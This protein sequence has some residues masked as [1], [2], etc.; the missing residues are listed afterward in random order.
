MYKEDFLVQRLA[1]CAFVLSLGVVYSVSA[2]ELAIFLKAGDLQGES[3]DGVHKDEIDLV[4]FTQAF[5]ERECS[6][7]TVS[8]RIDRASP[9]LSSRAVTGASFPQMVITVV[10]RGTDTN[11]EFLKITYQDVVVKALSI[12][13]GKQEVTEQILLD[14][15]VTTVE[16]KPQLPKGALGPAITSTVGCRK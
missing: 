7:L 4:S 16:Y 9:E 6:T 2:Q 13:P 15:R 11:Q 3:I 8:K 5:E 14:P 10:R 1:A 12:T